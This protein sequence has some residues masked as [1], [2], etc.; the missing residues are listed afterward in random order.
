M[1]YINYFNTFNELSSITCILS[2]ILLK[3]RPEIISVT[4]DNLTLYRKE[5]AAYSCHLLLLNV[6]ASRVV[7]QH[8]GEEEA[9]EYSVV[10]QLNK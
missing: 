8:T 6:P 7:L 10:K 9:R 5:G 4:S 2:I 3:S 1:L